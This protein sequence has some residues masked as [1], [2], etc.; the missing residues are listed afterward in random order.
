MG[1]FQERMHQVFGMLFDISHLVRIYNTILSDLHNEGLLYLF[2]TESELDVSSGN[3]TYDL[4]SDFFSPYRVFFKLSDGK[5]FE[6]TMVAPRVATSSLGLPRF[7]AIKGNKIVVFPSPS[8]DGKLIVQYF[9]VM[10]PLNLADASLE[11]ETDLMKHMPFLVEAGMKF[12]IAE[13]MMYDGL[14]VFAAEYTRAKQNAMAHQQKLLLGDTLVF[15]P[16]GEPPRTGE[17]G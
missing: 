13:D 12:Y 7:F 1:D 8:V 17:R 6:L 11:T 4:P 2:F 14:Q 3:P 15:R 9:P 5:V 10:M 16:K